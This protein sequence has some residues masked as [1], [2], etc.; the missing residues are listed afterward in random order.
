[1]IHSL[2]LLAVLAQPVPEPDT[3]AGTAPVQ[4]LASIDDKGKMTITHVDCNCYGPGSREMT[5]TAHETKG[6]KKVPVQAKVKL[7]SLVLTT[8]EIQAKFVEAYTVDGKAIAADKLATML[9]KER[10]VIVALDGKKVDPFHLQLYKEST[11]VLVPPANT[12]NLGYG[13]GYGVPGVVEPFPVPTPFPEKLPKE[14]KEP[15]DKK[16]EIIKPDRD[17][18]RE[19]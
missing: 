19:K 9:A 11:I 15:L 5:V 2:V 3:S 13:G 16:P 7:T 6:E 10:A 17:F 4:A 8:A 18:K 12:L 1:L 14:P